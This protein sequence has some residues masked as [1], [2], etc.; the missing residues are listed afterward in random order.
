MKKVTKFETD[1]EML[2]RLYLNKNP[3]V[4]ERM[5][6]NVPLPILLLLLGILIIVIS[7]L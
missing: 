7:H 3:Q 1:K 2:R 4:R 6:M 5:T